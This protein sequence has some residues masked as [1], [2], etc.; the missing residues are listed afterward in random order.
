[1]L[2]NCLND[3][4]LLDRIKKLLRIKIVS[5]SKSTFNDM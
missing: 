1:M 4:N 3:Y 2:F 5:F